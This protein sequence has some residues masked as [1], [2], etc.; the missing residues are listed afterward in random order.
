MLLPFIKEGLGQGER[1]FQVV[2]GALRQEHLRR[3]EQAGIDVAA[4]ERSGQLEV[5]AWEQTYLRG[6]RFD[7]EAMLALLQELLDR[8]RAQGFPRTRLVMHM[9]WALEARPGVE[10]LVEYEARAND[11]LRR[12][13]DAVICTFDVTR[14][15]GGTIV[16]ILRTH[17]LAII[18]SLLQENPF[19]L[20]P[21]QFLRELRPRATGS[22]TM[23]RSD[24]ADEMD[25]RLLAS[26]V[27]SDE[28]GELRRYLRD[29]VIL[30]GL[31]ALW[32]GQSPQ[33]IVASFADAL[34][35]T[36]RLDFVYVRLLSG[37]E[38]EPAVE[39]ACTKLGPAGAARARAIGQALAPWLEAEEHAGAPWIASPIGDG[40]VALAVTSIGHSGA[41]LGL[42]AT[43]A[44]RNDFPAEYDRLLLRVG[45]NQVAIALQSAQ[46]RA[47][48]D[49]IAEGSGREEALRRSEERFRALIERS[50]DVLTLQ[51]RDWTMTY[52]SPS[53]ARLLGYAPAGLVGRSVLEAVH[54]E[55]HPRLRQV[56]ANLLERPGE[57]ATARYR[58]RH[59][60][61]SWRWFEATATNL[62][63]VPAVGSIVVNRRD[64]TAEVEAQQLLEQRVA[65]RTR[66]LA[67]LLEVA[68]TMGGTLE[69]QPLLGL[70]LDQLKTVVDYSAAGVHS[71]VKGEESAL[72]EYR[73]P[74]PREHMIGRRLPPLLAGIVQDVLDRAAPVI[75][76]DWG[77]W[78]PV[79]EAVAAEGVELPSEALGHSRAALWLPLFVKGEVTGVLAIV[80]PRPGF[81]TEHHAQLAMAFAQQAGTAIENARL[82]E[83]TRVKAVLEERQRLARELHDSVTQGLYSVLL[84]TEAANR[85]LG[86]GAVETARE[87]LRDVRA[88]TR[89]A[90]SEM[91]L[92]VFEL[93]QPV[94]EAHGLSAAL[95]ARLATVEARS[96]LTAD[97]RLD[98]SILLP[99]RVEQDLYRIAQEALNN[100]LRHARARRVAV[101]LEARGDRVRLDVAD[102]GAGFDPAQPSGGLGLKGMR[103]RAESHGGTLT[104]ESAPG[105]GTRVRVEVPR[106]GW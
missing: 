72:L 96:G 60:D 89:E 45:A 87:H 88:A 59:R 68:R 56:L 94:L 19:F 82:H 4:A 66:E 80:H 31:P 90:L 54:P 1:A 75:V 38:T 17:P 12:Y 29:V 61:G 85:Q 46:L 104:I 103:E 42:V 37:A 16:D 13:D 81:Y 15:G 102:D 70:I 47:T 91:R 100:I 55:D 58:L 92:L 63:D 84:W 65:E 11:L 62:L 24:G 79:M 34:L 105:A 48:Q 97:V 76:E 39:T 35:A 9:E 74:L 73:G 5:R 22:A 69:L 93:R 8:G 41:S 32:V 28:F 106:H 23:P 86:A 21:D 77:E 101:T 26:E 64:V 44:R 52:V 10:H 99:G 40:L 49:E 20:P 50:S 53:A 6:G 83:A 95:R 30:S 36:L 14:F 27:S 98:E 18:G 78:P 71:I 51:Q 3:L 2:D 7:P 67:A 33:A 57:S 25:P 43:G